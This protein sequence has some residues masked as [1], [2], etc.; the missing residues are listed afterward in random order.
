MTERPH[1]PIGVVILTIYPGMCGRRMLAQS[2]LLFQPPR[3]VSSYSWIIT[4]QG[5]NLRQRPPLT[6]SVFALPTRALSSS[7]RSSSGS[8]GSNRSRGI[9]QLKAMR[10]GIE[11]PEDAMDHESKTYKSIITNWLERVVIGLKLC[12]WASPA[13]NT[14]AITILIHRGDDLEGIAQVILEQVTKLSE[15]P[16]DSPQN[17]T[18]LIGLPNVLEDFDE[19]LDFNGYVC[20]SVCIFL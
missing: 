10:D 2:R 6:S 11:V 4:F 8:G 15:I 16:D 3:P 13:L 18:V 20:I 7:S 19:Y 12:P 5:A 1:G 17:A 9:E 14:K